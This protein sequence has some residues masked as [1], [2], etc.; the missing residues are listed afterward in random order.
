MT[1]ERDQP[2]IKDRIRSLKQKIHDN[3]ERLAVAEG[4]EQAARLYE[5]LFSDLRA[6]IKSEGTEKEIVAMH[7]IIQEFASV[8]REQ[9]TEEASTIDF[10]PTMIYTIENDESTEVEVYIEAATESKSEMVKLAWRRLE[11]KRIDQYQRLKEIFGHKFKSD[12]VLHDP[13]AHARDI[14]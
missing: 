9:I 5:A 7:P 1:Q 4:P 3:E 6:W 10:N 13:K 14:V 11:E 8:K 2:I 12:E